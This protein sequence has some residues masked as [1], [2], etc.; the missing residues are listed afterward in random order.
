MAAEALSEN[1]VW[2]GG[3]NQAGAGGF[4]FH[5][6]GQLFIFLWGMRLLCVLLF[7]Y[8]V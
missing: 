4:A 8:S 5:T 6:T 7:S 3:G 2:I 1:E